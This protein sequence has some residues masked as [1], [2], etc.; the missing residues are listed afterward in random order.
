MLLYFYA[1]QFT[2]G[3]S[4]KDLTDSTKNIAKWSTNITNC[5]TEIPQNIKVELN[6]GTLTLKSGSKVYYPDGFEE[7]GTTKKFDTYTT[8]NDIP[9]VVPSTEPGNSLSMVVGL[10][11]LGGNLFWSH[12]SNIYSGDTQPTS[13]NGCMWYDTTTNRIKRYNSSTSTWETERGGYKFILPICLFTTSDSQ[14]VKSL[15]QVFNGFGYIGSTVFALPGV[16]GLVPNG[17][18]ADGTLNN[19]E[20]TINKVITRHDMGVNKALSFSYNPV[21]FFNYSTY[22]IT[23]DNYLNSMYGTHINEFVCGTYETDSNGKITKFNPKTVFR[24]IDYSDKSIITGWSMPST[25]YVDLT[26]P[27]SGGTFTVPANGWVT[28]RADNVSGGYIEIVGPMN[29]RMPGT[30]SGDMAFFMPVNKSFVYKVFYIGFTNAAVF[31]FIY[32]EGE[33]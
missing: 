1:D 12:V 2:D 20:L 16:K 19:S 6:S 10:S 13:F 3:G 23:E 11:D 31:R 18:N 24:A 17:R 27:A 29:F 28:F 21:N 32:A 22:T 4:G 8:E 5:I 7:D 9:L 26:L 30:Q 14:T 15:D 33:I 25:K